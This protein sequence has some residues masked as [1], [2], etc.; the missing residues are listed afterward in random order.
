LLSPAASSAI[1]STT[2][3]AA[4]TIGSGIEGATSSLVSALNVLGQG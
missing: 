2:T 4:P 3:T 1:V